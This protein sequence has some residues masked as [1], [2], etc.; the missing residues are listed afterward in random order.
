MK[1]RTLNMVRRSDL[2]YPMGDEDY[3]IL[4]ELKAPLT[5]I[6]VDMVPILMNFVAKSRSAVTIKWHNF[7]EIEAALFKK[8]KTNW[9]DY[10]FGEPG[11]KSVYWV[12]PN[13]EDYAN[14]A[15]VLSKKLQLW[16]K[17][18]HVQTEVETKRS[19]TKIKVTFSKG[20]K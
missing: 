13:T 2:A 7:S 20:T 14:K 3:R 8:I 4:L 12:V 11:T 16:Y 9:P 15:N 19:R 6:S 17:K 18:N 10:F 5:K 1:K